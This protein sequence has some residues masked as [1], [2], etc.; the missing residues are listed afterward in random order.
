MKLQN[1]IFRV[2][3]QFCQITILRFQYLSEVLQRLNYLKQF[4][5]EAVAR[6]CSAKKLFLKYSQNLQE[7]TSVE[8]SF[9]IKSILLK[10]RLQYSCFP[11]SQL[12][13]LKFIP[14]NWKVDMIQTF[15]INKRVT[16]NR[17]VSLN[18]I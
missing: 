12:I 15:V 7:N 18:I 4:F 6:K 5:S 3:K 11:C 2:F 8:V 14:Q 1:I 17:E 9:I 10:K 13:H 16:G